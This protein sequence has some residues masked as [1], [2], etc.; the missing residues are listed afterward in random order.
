MEN[1]MPEGPTGMCLPNE[2]M[3][4]THAKVLISVVIDS[5]DVLCLV[6]ALVT[7]KMQLDLPLAIVGDDLF[8]HSLPYR[9][10]KMD[11]NDG[12]ARIL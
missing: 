8:K 5:P 9:P 4:E 1:C 3:W 6:M 2:Q 10:R 12:Q 7:G 11:R